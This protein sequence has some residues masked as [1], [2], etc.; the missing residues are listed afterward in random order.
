MSKEPR[1]YWDQ[2]APA[3]ASDAGHRRFGR[4]L[5]LY[6]ESCWRY[7]EPVLPVAEGSTILEVGCGTGRWVTRLA[8][9][10]YHVVLADLSPTMIEQ[11][12]D[13]VERLGLGD[14]VV[15]YHVLDICDMCAF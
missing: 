3:Y 4:F 5:D 2:Q 10:G 14:R 11:A 9:M 12:R 15:G 7:I 8:P 1:E 13:K 6:E